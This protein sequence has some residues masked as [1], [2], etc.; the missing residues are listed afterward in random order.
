MSKIKNGDLDDPHT[1]YREML[2]HFPPK[3]VQGFTY[4]VWEYAR[5]MVRS[6]TAMLQVSHS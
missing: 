6:I 3:M 5:S 1:I 4:D 2:P